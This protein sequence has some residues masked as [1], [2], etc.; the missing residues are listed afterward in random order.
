MKNIF[1]S[2]FLVFQT[3]TLSAQQQLVFKDNDGRLKW[4][5]DKTEAFFGASIIRRLLHMAIVKF[6]E[7]RL[8]ISALSKMMLIT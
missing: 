6:H 5:K 4:S 2:I 8:T 7:M 1:I 3:I